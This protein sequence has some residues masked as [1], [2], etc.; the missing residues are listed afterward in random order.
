MIFPARSMEPTIKPGSKVIVDTQ[1]FDRKDPERFDLVAFSPP[2]SPEQQFVFTVI[3][4]P[5]ETIMLDGSGLRIDGIEIKHPNGVD[6]IAADKTEKH[7]PVNGIEIRNEASLGTDQY[8]VLG[9]NTTNALDSRYF[10]PIRRQAI[11][12]KITKI[13]QAEDTDAE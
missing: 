9:D 13:E 3:G 12:G 1:A 8:F 7:A 5:G 10:G 11:H 2:H 6:Y 4:L